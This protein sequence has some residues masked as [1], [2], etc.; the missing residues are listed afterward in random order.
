[1]AFSLHSKPT[2][3]F[4]LGFGSVRLVVVDL[5]QNL[6]VKRALLDVSM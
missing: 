5:V 4:W 1:M 2:Q 3:E 6:F